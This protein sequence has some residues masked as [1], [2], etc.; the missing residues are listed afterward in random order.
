MAGRPLDALFTRPQLEAIVKPVIDATFVA[1]ERCLAQANLS[2]KDLSN[3]F[4]VGGSALQPLVAKTLAA[5]AGRH[6][7]QLVTKQPHQAV[8]FGAALI[9]QQLFS[10]AAE[11]RRQFF[12]AAPYTLGIRVRDPVSGRSDIQPMI[13]RNTPVPAS[14]STTFYTARVDQARIIIDV[15]QA[16]ADGEIAQSLGYFAFGPIE[17][18]RKNYPIEIQ[19]SYDAEGMVTVRAKDPQTGK[20]LSQIMNNEED[21]DLTQYAREKDWISELRIND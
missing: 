7:D 11:E 20:S 16:G 4:L 6:V 19:L 18:P 2:W 21:I 9:G 3:F 17:K 14:V 13:K 10:A 5:R 1:S 12:P 15:V 8:A